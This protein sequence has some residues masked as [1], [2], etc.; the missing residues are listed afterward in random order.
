M[1]RASTHS[2]EPS[3]TRAARWAA[4]RKAS[5]TAQSPRNW[6]ALTASS[7]PPRSRA[8][9]ARTAP[10]DNGGQRESEKFS[11]SGRDGAGGRLRERRRRVGGLGPRQRRQP[12]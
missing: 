6:A 8:S 3:I 9:A 10:S 1:P 2:R 4:R 5:S 11:D 12:P 7:P